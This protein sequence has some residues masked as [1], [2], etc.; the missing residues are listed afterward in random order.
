M[1]K[2]R[3]FLVFN[4]VNATGG[5]EVINKPFNESLEALQKLV[6]GC[7]EHYVIDEDLNDNYIDMWI[8]DEG[9]FRDDFKPMFALLHDGKL[10]DVI[11]GPCVFTMYDRDGN[12]LGLT[13][14]AYNRVLNFLYSC[15]TCVVE[16]KDGKSYPCLAVSK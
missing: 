14:D 8:N 16:T 6:D 5:I 13:S 7:I 11:V 12:T 2:N 1:S 3:F 15:P 4:G 9:K 10:Y